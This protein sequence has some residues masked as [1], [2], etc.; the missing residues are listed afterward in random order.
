MY[1]PASLT[2]EGFVHCTGDDDTLLA[3]ANRFYAAVDDDRGPQARPGGAH[4]PR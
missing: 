1:E 4:Q 3:V 2:T